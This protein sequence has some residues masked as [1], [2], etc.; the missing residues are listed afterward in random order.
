MISF[1]FWLHNNVIHIVLDLCVHHV[2]KDYGHSRL[3][4]GSG[5]FETEGHNSV[6]KVTKRSSKGCF[7]CIFGWHSNMII[8]IEAIHEWKHSM[9]SNWINKHIHVGKWKFIFGACF[10]K[11]PE[12]NKASYLPILLL[13]WYYIWKP[14]WMHDRLN[15]PSCEK[16]LDFLDNLS[17]NIRM[18]GLHGLYYWLRPWIHI[19]SMCT[20]LGSKLSISLYSQAKTSMYSFNSEMR[21]AF[22]SNGKVAFTEVGRWT[23]GS[24]LRLMVSSSTS[25]EKLVT[26]GGSSDSSIRLLGRFYFH[27]WGLCFLSIIASWCNA[28]FIQSKTLLFDIARSRVP[29]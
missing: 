7:G 9:P 18:E 19:E 22:S 2:M 10:T 28:C 23:L 26:A 15:K 17:F 20:R 29:S 11:I 13:N 12:I 5:I 14:P 25:G 4:C 6:I 3:I 16:F 24:S 1:G 21:W 27:R 8:A